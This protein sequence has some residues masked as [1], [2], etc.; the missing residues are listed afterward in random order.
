MDWTFFRRDCPRGAGS[1]LWFGVPVL[2]SYAV[3]VHAVL[4]IRNSRALGASCRLMRNSISLKLILSCFAKV[5]NW[6]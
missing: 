6:Y 4:S 2:G 5:L 1:Q 3:R